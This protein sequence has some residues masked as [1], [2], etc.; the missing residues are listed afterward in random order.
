MANIPVP[1]QSKYQYL[2]LDLQSLLKTSLLQPFALKKQM[3]I[4]Y[5]LI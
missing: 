1:R 5:S 3:A 4:R 2:A